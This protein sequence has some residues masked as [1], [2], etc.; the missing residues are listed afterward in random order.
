MSMKRKDEPWKP[1]KKG[2]SESKREI[3]KLKRDFYKV[4]KDSAG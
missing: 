2:E 1:R 3:D 4:W